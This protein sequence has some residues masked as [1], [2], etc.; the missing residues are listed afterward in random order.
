[1]SNHNQ[2]QSTT[3][4]SVFNFKDQEVRI[5]SIDNSTY[6]IL[7]DVCKVLD[8]GDP[9]RVA[10][11]LDPDGTTFSRVIDLLGR[12]QEMLC[13]NEPNLYRTIFRSNK[14]EAKTFQDWVFKE[15]L[16]SIRKTGSY[17]MDNR[18]PKEQLQDQLGMLQ[19]VH[20]I[21]RGVFKA[22]SQRWIVENKQFALYGKV[23]FDYFRLEVMRA[24]REYSAVVKYFHGENVFDG[25]NMKGDIVKMRSE[26]KEGKVSVQLQFP[27]IED[28]K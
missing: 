25:L 4:L 10:D 3:N 23:A 12:E 6:W 5:L 2:E 24:N 18:S 11:R 17:S 22:L 26:I 15:V 8:L 9:S 20:K 21:V 14:P 1:M 16:P 19:F 13:V 28:A 27:F 7:A